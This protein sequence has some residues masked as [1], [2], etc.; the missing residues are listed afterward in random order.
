MKK[1]IFLLLLLVGSTAI[2]GGG[3]GHGEAGVPMGTVIS[4]IANFL[5]LIGIVYVWQGKAISKAFADK[6]TSFLNAVDEASR[7]KR[8]AEEKMKEV[9]GR[10]SEMKATYQ[11]EVESAKNNAEESYRTQLADAKNEAV[12]IKDSALGS[13]ESEVQKEIENLR[14]ETY[15]KSV[16]KAE[17]K[18]GTSLSA[19][20]Q[21]AW[22]KHFASEVSEVH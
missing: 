1:V 11:T 13:L 5:L 18:L 4:Q 9:E 2:A 20:Q 12:R 22:N 10:V 21:K 14:L 15:Q 19:D 6:R 3:G 16:E 7:S 17:Q 8:E